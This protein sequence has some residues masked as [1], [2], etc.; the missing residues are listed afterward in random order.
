MLTSET[1]PMSGADFMGTGC[2]LLSGI[3]SPAWDAP[4]H[5]RSTRHDAQ[6]SGEG[7]SCREGA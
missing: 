1:N 6:R 4:D 5:P 2:R 3:D 7:L